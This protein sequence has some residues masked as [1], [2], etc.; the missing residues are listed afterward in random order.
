[1]ERGYLQR[2]ASGLPATY[3]S[4]LQRYENDPLLPK[5]LAKLTEKRLLRLSGQTYDVYNDVFKEYIVF[6]RLPDSSAA[7]L[8]KIGPGAVMNAFRRLGG[9]HKLSVE[10]L[11]HEFKRPVGSVHNLLRELRVIGLACRS[12]AGWE[13]P[14]VVRQ[15]ESQG[16]ARRVHPAGAA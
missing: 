1:M 16:A 9:R 7:F 4:L 6:N 3:Q 10:D 5:I 2:L 8:F 15:Y 11:S 13:V 14:Q 12:A